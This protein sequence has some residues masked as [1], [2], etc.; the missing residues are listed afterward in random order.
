MFGHQG[1]AGS[2]VLL[3]P[4]IAS[5]ISLAGTSQVADT[6]SDRRCSC[7]FPGWGC[8]HPDFKGC[9]Q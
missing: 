3:F 2:G 1:L 6:A 9:E 8:R 5:L 4:R 7:P